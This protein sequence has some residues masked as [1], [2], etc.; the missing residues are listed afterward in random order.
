MSRIALK[1]SMTMSAGSSRSTRLAISF[2]IASTPLR[3]SA[4]PMSTKAMVRSSRLASKNENSCMY[5]TSLSD[6]SDSVVK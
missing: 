2:S 5:C 6:G 3:R 1:L 4:A